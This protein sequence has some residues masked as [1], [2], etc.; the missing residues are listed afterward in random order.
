MTYKRTDLLLPVE[1]VKVSTTII[2]DVM[3]PLTIMPENDPILYLLSIA[4]SRL[5]SVWTK[6]G[7]AVQA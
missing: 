1:T 3:Y 4:K 2:P 7:Y 6:L 5:Y